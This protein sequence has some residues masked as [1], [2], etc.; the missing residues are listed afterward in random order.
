MT[1]ACAGP[2][3][4]LTFEGAPSPAAPADLDARL[5]RPNS[6]RR[7]GEGSKVAVHVASEVLR[8]AGVEVGERTGVYVGQ[9]QVALDYCVE[10]VDSSYRNGPRLAS[11]MLFSESVAN[12]AATHLSLTLK[13]TGVVQTFIG[14]RAAGI[15]AL[16]AAAE[17]LSAG[18]IDAGLVVVLSFS[19][20]LTSDAFNSIFRPFARQRRPAPLRFRNGGVA[21]LLRRPAPERP[22]GRRITF[23]GVRSCGP[24]LEAQVAALRG[25]WEDYRRRHP[26]PRSLLASAFCLAH[27]RSREVLRRALGDEAPALADPAGE[28]FALEPVLQLLEGHA[29]PARA[30]VCLGEDG[31]AGLLAAEEIGS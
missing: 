28:A 22:A 21:V 29:G 27:S 13:A 9:Q 14:S 24:G 20:G 8:E 26:R 30:V 12:N 3:R 7:A 6:L 16:Q 2:F 5:P 4:V 17:D 11:P 10:F 15:Q 18:G 31:S 1:A 23:A 25:L 19:N